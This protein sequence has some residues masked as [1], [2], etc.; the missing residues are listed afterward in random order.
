MSEH[1]D[2]SQVNKAVKE[3]KRE[4]LKAGLVHASI[5]SAILLIGL[6]VVISKADPSF[7]PDG[8]IAVSGVAVSKG[9][10][11]AVGVSFVFFILDVFWI[12]RRNTVKKFE[13]FNPEIQEV[14]RTARDT[15]KDDIDNPIAQRLYDE[16]IEK[17][18]NSSSAGFI[19][20]KRIATTILILLIIALLFAYVTLMGFNYMPGGGFG[21]QGA[22]PG[23]GQG[24]SGSQGDSSGA[25]SGDKI[26]YKGLQDGDQILG[27]KGNLTTG[28]NRK[29]INLSESGSAEDGGA[30]GAGSFS[31]GDGSGPSNPGI[32][33]ERSDYQTETNID[34][35]EAR[36]MREYYKKRNE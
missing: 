32:D 7:I 15:A 25:A 5:E 3:V 11:V 10:L 36:L 27:E 16:T 8:S 34:R 21:L 13:E 9:S 28:S 30:G 2:I 19:S 12:Y 26:K 24:A 31:S 20:I 4:G 18:K 33:V 6:V 17:L 23:V 1:Y 14:L 22:G 35:E 29:T